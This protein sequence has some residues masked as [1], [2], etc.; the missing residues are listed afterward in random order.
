M[1]CSCSASL[2]SRG[3]RAL[4]IG[5]GELV[6]KSVEERGQVRRSR[7]SDLASRTS[8]AP[9]AAGHLVSEAGGRSQAGK[10]HPDDQQ[11]E[12]TAHVRPPCFPRQMI[13]PPRPE[14]KWHESNDPIPHHVPNHSLSAKFQAGDSGTS[15]RTIR[16]PP[17]PTLHLSASGLRPIRQCTWFASP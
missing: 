1:P 2:G 14:A 17:A 9:R 8:S 12:A 11:S 4:A 3:V 5:H 16:Q 10:H 15:Q 6:V 13:H 7:Q